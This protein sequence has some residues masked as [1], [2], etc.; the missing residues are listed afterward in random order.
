MG[1][2][3]SRAAADKLYQVGTEI[4]YQQ[5]HASYRVDGAGGG[6]ARLGVTGAST[7]AR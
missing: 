7:D 6:T 2:Y 1:V 3:L 5:A 4:L